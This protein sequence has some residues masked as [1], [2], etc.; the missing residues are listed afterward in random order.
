MKY[1]KVIIMDAVP[2]ENILNFSLDIK[3]RSVTNTFTPGRDAGI[4]PVSLEGYG[5]FYAESNYFTERRG[6]DSW[7]IIYT[8]GGCGMIRTLQ[9]EKILGPGSLVMIDCM[10]YQFYRTASSEG[11]NFKWFHCK[12]PLAASYG[13]IINA[14]GLNVFAGP[15]TDD[16]GMLIDELFIIASRKASY[17]DILVSGKIIGILNKTVEIM[18]DMR[19]G[20]K[21]KSCNGCIDGAVDLIRESFPERISLEQMAEHAHLSKYHFLRIFKAATGLTPHE[22]LISYSINASK[23]LLWQTSLSVSEIAV[24]CGFSDSNSFIRSFK[25]LCGVTPNVYRKEKAFPL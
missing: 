7:L 20:S 11:W 24:E 14:E 13:T 6:L 22:Y 23:K 25:K 12:G 9:E 8:F 3:S 17:A 2:S 21:E 15:E 10:E 4:L 19:A 5:C 18:L 1:G 16:T